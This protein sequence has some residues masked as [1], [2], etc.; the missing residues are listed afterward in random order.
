MWCHMHDECPGHWG[1]MVLPFAVVHPLTKESTYV[2]AVAPRN[3]RPSPLV[4]MSVSHP[5]TKQYASLLRAST[6]EQC[7]RC[8]DSIFTRSRFDPTLSDRFRGKTGR[9]R[10][11]IVGRRVNNS[12]RSVITGDPSLRTC[13]VGVPY[14]IANR[15]T[16][17][18]RVTHVNQWRVLD[19]M[20]EADRRAE[21]EY[22]TDADHLPLDGLP[23]QL[24]VG[25]VVY[26]P[27]RDGDLVVLNRQPTLH[28]N[29]MVGMEV[30]R[31]PHSTIRINPRVT[32]GF[33]ADFDGDEMNIFAVQTPEAR[34]EVDSLM[35]IRHHAAYTVDI[36]DSK[37]AKHLGLDCEGLRLRGHSVCIPRPL[38]MAECRL[39]ENVH[40]YKNRALTRVRAEEPLNSPWRA[41]VESGSKGNWGNICAIRACLGQQ[42][43]RGAIPS[44]IHMW[45]APS[46]GAQGFVHSS[47]TTGLTSKE[48][49]FHCMAGRDGL[50]DTAIRTGDVGYKHRRIARFLDE[51]RVASDG[52]IR[53]EH[54]QLVR[55]ICSCDPG[56]R[57]GLI[58]AQSIGEPATQLTL[59]TFHS[60][61]AISE[62][63]T[64]GLARMQELL[65]WSKVNKHEMRSRPSNGHAG[66]H[67]VVRA[68]TLS[69]FT[70][71]VRGGRCM[72]SRDAL[73]LYDTDVQHIARVTGATAH[74]EPWAAE[75]WVELTESTDGVRD[76][77]M[78]ITG[79]AGV[80]AAS[81]RDGRLTLI[82][83][84]RGRFSMDESST[85]PWTVYKQLGIEAARTV[86]EREMNKVVAVQNPAHIRLLAEYMCHSGKPMPC[87]QRAFAGANTLR[88]AAY[89]RAQT[90]FPQAGRARVV[91][92]IC[93]DTER[94]AFSTI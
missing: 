36:Q 29:S 93:T 59:N 84:M 34:A 15:L 20:F 44:A 13:E 72:L 19:D 57:V 10:A 82:G 80:R 27:L 1:H 64:S 25:M 12:A 45:E 46:R 52:T 40:D 3:I 5:L 18:V 11:N 50:I 22:W 41:M 35:H 21:L 37:L 58:A 2:I 28:R 7:Q 65:Q 76:G 63:T 88:A 48:F 68:T 30:V 75:P 81:V 49:F 17:Q 60:S 91:E 24:P 23:G 38:R 94:I 43:I 47:Y 79:E 54:G 87:S 6:A 61:G 77:W 9:L 42:F 90:I 4:S 8:V 39:L 67:W 70:E 86:W 83:E 26:R 85:N 32:K 33:N 51:L 55:T 56:E 31:V 69:T 62:I 66:E 71:E 73:L 92:R 78:P 14:S 53:D 16:V 89:E 74:S